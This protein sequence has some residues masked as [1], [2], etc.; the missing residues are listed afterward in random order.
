MTSSQQRPINLFRV[1]PASALL[2][3]VAAAT[4]LVVRSLPQN[5]L[6]WLAGIALGLA[7]LPI[8]ASP[9][10]WFV[11]RYVY[12]RHLTPLLRPIYEVHHQA[13]HHI[14]FPTWRY[15]TGGAPRRLPILGSDRARVHTTAVGN[16]LVRLAHWLFYMTFGLVLIWPPLWLLT[17]GLP[18]LTGVA[19]ASAVV[20]DLFITVHDAIHRPGT[21]PLLERQPWF[22][23]LDAHHYIHHVDT[24]ANVNF[25]LPLSDWLFG[26]L[27]R[28]LTPEELA[29]HGTREA[30]KAHPEGEGEPA[31]QSPA[32]LARRRAAA[33]AL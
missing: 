24:E 26:T 20:S 6:G 1:L 27:R 28:S 7:V 15:V 12:H 9:I 18:F 14:F 23:F 11:H 16:G 8:L 29:R 2:L 4:V 25:L 3:L 31:A 32:A 13:H 5:P 19:I 17:H 21:H 33:R 10:E 30:A 22:H